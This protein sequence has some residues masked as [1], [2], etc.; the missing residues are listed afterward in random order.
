M[1]GSQALQSFHNHQLFLIDKH[2]VIWQ[3]STSRK[4]THL[5]ASLSLPL[6]SKD[7]VTY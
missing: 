3:I 6:S 1:A 7:G 4:L 5:F 2:M